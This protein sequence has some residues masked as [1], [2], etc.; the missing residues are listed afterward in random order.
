MLDVSI[1]SVVIKNAIVLN[2]VAPKSDP[3]R[4]EIRKSNINFFVIQI[5]RFL[6][7]PELLRLIQATSFCYQW[8]LIVVYFSFEETNGSLFSQGFVILINYFN[9]HILKL[10]L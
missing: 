3:R 8:S 10:F 5:F 2:V 1:L 9:V 6:N 4:K 7:F